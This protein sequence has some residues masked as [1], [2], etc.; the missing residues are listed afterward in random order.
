MSSPEQTSPYPGYLLVPVRTP[1]NRVGTTGVIVSV[2]GALMALVGTALPW[3][4]VH[5]VHVRLQDFTA[6]TSA[7]AAKA[8][9]HAYFG[10]LLWVLLA[11]TIIAALLAAVPGPL[12]RTL[13]ILSPLLGGLSALLMLVSLGQLEEASI[14]NHTALGF[15]VILIGFIS[16]G[17]GGSFGPR[18]R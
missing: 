4:S 7:S 2:A 15:W 17:L 9:P 12:S 11:L 8:L 6:G 13:R 16:T 3:Y 14:Y 1:R 18:R 5:G 10:W